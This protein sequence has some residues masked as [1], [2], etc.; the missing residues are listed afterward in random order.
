MAKKI[1]PESPISLY[2]LPPIES[3]L[4]TDNEL[5]F[6]YKQAVE[7]AEK[8][9]WLSGSREEAYRLAEDAIKSGDK[10]YGNWLLENAKKN[11]V[12]FGVSEKQPKVSAV[13]KSKPASKKISEVKS[14]TTNPKY[15]EAQKKL[16]E[17]YK[18]LPE[19]PLKKR[20]IQLIGIAGKDAEINEFLSKLEKPSV[21]AVPKKIIPQAVSTE[22]APV[23]SKKTKIR[24]KYE[25]L[26]DEEK[27]RYKQ[28]LEAAKSP[29][30]LPPEKP[31]ATPEKLAGVPLNKAVEETS[32]PLFK[33]LLKKHGSRVLPW[34][35]GL[36]EAP[37]IAELA[38]EGDVAG[39]GRKS[40]ELVGTIAGGEL[41]ALAGLGVGSIPLG[42]AGA[43]AGSKLAGSAYDEANIA[44]GTQYGQKL[45][46]EK[47]KLAED[48]PYK[49]QLEWNPRTGTQEF[50]GDT[51]TYYKG[52]DFVPYRESDRPK[53]LISK[54]L[55][56]KDYNKNIT[57]FISSTESGGEKDP[58]T[59]FNTNKSGERMLG[60]YQLK[61]TFH[62][63]EFER[64]YG[65]PF[66][67]MVKPENYRYQ[68]DYFNKKVLPERLRDAERLAPKAAERGIDKFVL[69]GILQLGAGNIEKYLNGE[70]LP[71]E[72]VK[73]IENY[74]QRG[75]K[76]K[77]K[78]SGESLEKMQKEGSYLPFKSPQAKMDTL[79]EQYYKGDKEIPIQYKSLKPSD[80]EKKQSVESTEPIEPTGELLEKEAPERT[81]A[82]EPSRLEKA[83]ES[84]KMLEL[85]GMA[86]SA[87]EKFAGGLAGAL[88]RTPPVESYKSDLADKLSRLGLYGVQEAQLVSK[89]KEEK[90]L[91]DPNS[92]KSKKLQDYLVN[93]MGMSRDQVKDLSYQD[94]KDFGVSSIYLKTKQTEAKAAGEESKKKEKLT[95]SQNKFLDKEYAQIDG[96]KITKFKRH[97]DTTYGTFLKGKDQ[98]GIFDVNRLYAVLK[99]LDPDSA[100]R[101]GEVEL[102]REAMTLFDNIEIAVN[103]FNP[104]AKEAKIISDKLSEDIENLIKMYKDATDIHYNQLVNNAAYRGK[105]IGL[106]PE[107][108]AASVDAFSTPNI[109]PSS[110]SQTEQPAPSEFKEMKK[111]PSLS[112]ITLK[113]K[114]QPGEGFSLNG[115][116]YIV[117]NDGLTL[118][119]YEE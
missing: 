77:E 52:K 48:L 53:S 5:D 45:Q 44:L 85:L 42:L 83:L 13:S 28:N 104:N 60:K 109:L 98:R 17:K 22:P 114:K 100:V 117:G 19:G 119:P 25:S 108:T 11:D 36:V 66:E 27:L 29:T 89:E 118:I 9:K 81:V 113:N 10:E 86:T 115:K 68:D 93:Y 103:K 40:A 62:K 80:A 51:A 72:N 20:A 37:E 49:K 38:K 70:E 82:S 76:F 102:S 46:E 99:A 31:V 71:E 33:S 61:D 59:A 79:L 2:D 32:E 96:H 74:I 4:P 64:M 39:A 92:E 67:D 15:S 107:E 87:S 94:Y 97:I 78:I 43:Y 1:N 105:R 91:Q 7:K 26:T 65:I 30:G 41:G 6:N 12:K 24:K 34:L 50:T 16:I 47:Q 95:D 58:Y 35:S 63:D 110:Y 54:I 69:A 56:D 18:E 88:G 116:N 75:E 90:E 8:N 3:K 101:P 111:T 112:P 21:E 14:E 106:E 23:E 73:E 57:D 84:R 55:P